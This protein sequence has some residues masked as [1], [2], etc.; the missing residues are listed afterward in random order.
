MLWATLLQGQQYGIVTGQSTAEEFT[1]QLY[2]QL[3]L[4]FSQKDEVFKARKAD[5]AVDYPRLTV[6]GDFTGNG[7]TELVCFGDLTYTPNMNPHYTNAVAKLFRPGGGRMVPSGTWYNRA[8]SLLKWEYVKFAIVANFNNDQLDDIALLYNDPSKE[9]QTI[10]VLES[11]GTGFSAPKTYFSTNRNEFNFTAVN[12]ACAGDF[13]GNGNP[14]IA[15]FYNYFG[16]DPA[17][18]QAIFHFESDGSALNLNAASYTG[19]KS[20]I[21]F[22]DISFALAEDYNSDGV[23]DIAILRNILPG[24]DHELLV[25][26][27]SEAGDLIPANYLTTLTSELDFSHITHAVPADFAEERNPDLLLLSKDSDTGAQEV[28]VLEGRAGS[29]LEPEKLEDTPL[30]EIPF[31]EISFI[32]KG[33]FD[34]LPEVFPTTWKDDKSG[35]VSFTFDDGTLGAFENGALALEA[36]GLTGTFYIFTDTTLEYDAPVA[37]TELIKEYAAIGFEIASHTYN[38]SNLGHIAAEDPDSLSAVLTKS[39]LELK[40]RFNQP[41]ISMSIPFGSF[42]QEALDSISKHF[43][44]ARTSQFG[45]NLSVPYDYYALRSWPI[46][47]TTSP[48]F[49][50]GLVSTAE[51]YGSYLP[52]MYH[53]ILDEPFDQESMIYSYSLDLLK[54]T[55]QLTRQRDVWIDS[56]ARVYKYIREREALQIEVRVPTGEDGSFSLILHENL[57]DSIFDVELT[58]HIAVPQWWGKHAAV[59]VGDTLRQAPILTGPSGD[60]ILVN[61]LPVDGVEIFVSEWIPNG[62]GRKAVYEAGSALSI[63]AGPNPFQHE[64]TITIEGDA[65]ESRQ[66]LLMNMQG[67]IVRRMETGGRK[68][69]RLSGNNLPPG[70]YIVGLVGS[71]GEMAYLKLQKY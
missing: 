37:G 38:H 7:I 25:F 4:P 50:D 49:V 55:I 3:P 11:T 5:L 9:E 29:F 31:E 1:I 69:I 2:D 70:V 21:N 61:Q 42:R 16:T 54:E 63:K 52:L 48:A 40:K 28:L 30:T 46:L 15:V 71:Q 26:E 67:S 36:A 51:T 65:A 64:T 44:T 27:G 60:Y 32:Q 34:T 35:A 56:H 14:G 20:E 68:S 66:L 10:Y 39:T 6:A 22:S 24:Q 41:A 12:F 62:L 19:I 13:K 43:Y 45:F 47:S 53:D 8:D 23:S 17:T 18:K 57:P 58:L 33:K 59:Y